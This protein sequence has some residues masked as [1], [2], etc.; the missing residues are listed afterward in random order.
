MGRVGGGTRRGRNVAKQYSHMK[1]SKIRNL[2]K[3]NTQRYEN[4]KTTRE[5]LIRIIVQKTNQGEK[6]RN[7]E[8]PWHSD[9]QA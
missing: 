9:L 1:F 7:A 3:K 2:N 4:K 6:S 8:I 5:T